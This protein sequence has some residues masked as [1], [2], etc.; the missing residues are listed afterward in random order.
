MPDGMT[1]GHGPSLGSFEWSDPLG[2]SG[3]LSPDERMVADAA[4]AYAADK[5]APRV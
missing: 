3:Q 4:A 1:T 2:L 5:L